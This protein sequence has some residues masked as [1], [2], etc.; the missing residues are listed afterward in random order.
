MYDIFPT[1]QYQKSLRNI[2]QSGKLPREKLDNLVQMLA[3]NTPLPAQYRDHELKGEYKGF[4]ECHV[5]GDLLLVY[6]KEKKKL[7]LIL[8]DIGSHAYLFK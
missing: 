2:K 8:A 3:K 5:Q 6:K 7:I 1:K 4:R